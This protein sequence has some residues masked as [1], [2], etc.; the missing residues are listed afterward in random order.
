ME[1]KTIA[2]KGINKIC[3]HDTITCITIIMRFLSHITYRIGQMF[4]GKKVW[5]KCKT[6]NLAK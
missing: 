5:Q 6:I 1:C 4:G 3:N 2:I